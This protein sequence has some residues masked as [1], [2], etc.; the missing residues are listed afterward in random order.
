MSAERRAPKSLVH[1]ESCTGGAEWYLG[2]KPPR[3][4]VAFRG[5]RMRGNSRLCE[6]AARPD[7]M[8]GKGID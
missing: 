1:Q 3:N 8:T 5:S 2:E 6:R 7:R 4:A